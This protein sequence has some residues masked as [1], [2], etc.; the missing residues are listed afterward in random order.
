VL[1]LP[2]GVA[3]GILASLRPGSIVDRA[4]V[5][6][7]IAGTSI[8]PFVTAVWLLLIFAIYWKV[9]PA[10]GA[11]D[12]FGDRL[13][14]LTL[15]AL[16]LMISSAALVTK[17]TRTAMVEVLRQDYIT[18]ARARGLRQRRVIVVHAFRNARVTVVT[19]A[20]LLLAHLIVG[21]VLVEIAFSLPGLGRLLVDSVEAKDVVVVQGVALLFGA[22]VIMINLLSDL[23]HLAVDP[24]IRF[25]V[26]AK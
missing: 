20:N 18:F 5:S 21:S 25:G 22:A 2:F 13:L 23:A 17:V 15:P 11:G 26:A 16:A 6:L 10:F 14:H 24:R 9:F 12:G 8:P 19:S 4:A 7:S 3:L 1:I